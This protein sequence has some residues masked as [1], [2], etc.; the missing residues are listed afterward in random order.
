MGESVTATHRLSAGL[1]QA[2]SGL[3]LGKIRGQYWEQNECV[4]L[5]SSRCTRRRSSCSS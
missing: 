4:F 3:D 1:R 5:S 2:I